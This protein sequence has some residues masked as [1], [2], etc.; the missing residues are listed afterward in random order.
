MSTTSVGPIFTRQWE[1]VPDPALLEMGRESTFGPQC[2]MIV[3]CD[4][5][6]GWTEVPHDDH[7]RA[8]WVSEPTARGVDCVLVRSTTD[9]GTEAS[10][11]DSGGMYFGSCDHY[12]ASAT[13]VTLPAWNEKTAAQLEK[14]LS[15]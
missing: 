15:K 12:T 8:W 14:E 7:H 10:S 4:G 2:L 13:Y 6:T 11:Q 5:E 9:L 3:G 1:H